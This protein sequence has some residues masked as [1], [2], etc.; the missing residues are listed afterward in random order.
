MSKRTHGN[1]SAL[2][3]RKILK[4]A[5]AHEN[6]DQSLLNAVALVCKRNLRVA[7]LSNVVFCNRFVCKLPFYEVVA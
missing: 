1:E 2:S 3:V 5:G 7:P 4:L 6:D